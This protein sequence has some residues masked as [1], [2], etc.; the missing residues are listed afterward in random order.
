MRKVFVKNLAL[1]Q[2]LNL[3]IKPVWLLVIDRIAQ[4]SL[5]AAYGEYF[6]I[7]NLTLLLNI[8]LDL[9]IQN[10]NNTKVAGNST[11]FKENFTSILLAKFT[12]SLLYFAIIMLIGMQREM[13]A[14]LLLIIGLNQIITSFILYLRSNISGLQKYTIDSLLSISD[15][16][17]AILFCIGFFYLNQIDIWHFAL[18]QIAGSMVTLII[19]SYLN[20][21]YYQQID[22]SVNWGQLKLLS[23][24]KKSIPYALLFALMGF[25]TRAD[26]MMMDWLLDKKDA[27]FHSSIYAQSFRLLD[28]ACMF[29]MLFSGLLL[30]MFSKLLAEKQDIKPLTELSVKLLMVIAI[31]V[32]LAAQF[33]GEKMMYALYHFNDIEELILSG[34]VFG[35]ILFCFVPMCFIYTFGTLLTAKGDIKAM[36]IFAVIAL[37]VNIGLNIILIP[38]FQSYGASFS[39]L[40]TQTIFAGL[41]TFR[42]FYI[43]KFKFHLKTMGQFVMLIVSLFGVFFLVKGLTN[44]WI[45]LGLF[46]IGTLLLVLA[47]RIFDIKNLLKIL[48]GNKQ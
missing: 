21:R 33:F 47:L 12:L 39:S 43:F 18:A 9:G 7:L 16:T 8:V 11:F 29:A 34:H 48:V 2:G 37:T 42:C 13:D 6:I 22:A 32:A 36:N 25:Y 40:I 31:P 38:R 30:P 19:A 15:K 20:I 17:F 23:V 44:I 24:L 28:A 26:V 3:I 41:C 1:L 10:Y 27:I 35:N 45:T 4:N 14:G 46:G 5:G